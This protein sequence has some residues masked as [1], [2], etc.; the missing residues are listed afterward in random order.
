[1]DFSKDQSDFLHKF[2]SL[3]FDKSL[4]EGSASQKADTLRSILAQLH[5]CKRAEL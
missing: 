1:M 4:S 5:Y 2:Q 3:V